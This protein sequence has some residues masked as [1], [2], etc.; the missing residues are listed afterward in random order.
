VEKGYSLNTLSSSNM[1]RKR[2]V[3]M[4]P[5]AYFTLIIYVLMV[6]T[7]V[8]LVLFFLYMIYRKEEE[9]PTK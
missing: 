4:D 5:D 6:L 2:G 1:E 7:F 3:Q 8:S 9:T